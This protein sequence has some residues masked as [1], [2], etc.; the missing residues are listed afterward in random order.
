VSPR[1]PLADLLAPHGEVESFQGEQ[2]VV[3]AGFDDAAVLQDV[4][5][6]GVHD[7]GKPVSDQDRD[8]MARRH[9]A[10]RVGDL[11]FGQRVERR[12]RLSP[13]LL[14]PRS[15]GATAPRISWP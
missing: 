12:G 15:A 3:S 7:G 2:L 1:P 9:F 10:D 8:H 6:V 5:T 14:R 4:D 13:T 11:L